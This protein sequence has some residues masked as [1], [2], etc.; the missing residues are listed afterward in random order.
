MTAAGDATATVAPL[1]R[2]VL[3]HQGGWDEVLL[4]ATPVVLF[5]VLLWAAKRRAD[6]E[7]AEEEL[8][9]EELA[10]ADRSDDD[11]PASP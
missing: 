8:A 6:A 10:A 4:V 9:E 2:S 3:A 1:A 7:L 5:G 11:G